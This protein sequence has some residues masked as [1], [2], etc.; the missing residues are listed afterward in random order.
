MKLA[1]AGKGG[2]GKTTLTHKLSATFGYDLLLEGA[3]ENPF[4][5]RFYH[6]QKQ[7]ALQTQLYFLLQRAE[8]LNALRQNDLFEP[9]RRCVQPLREPFVA[10]EIELLVD[11][12]ERQRHLGQSAARFVRE[13]GVVRA[14]ERQFGRERAGAPQAGQR[15]RGDL[16]VR[17]GHGIAGSLS[18][19]GVDSTDRGDARWNFR[20]RA[21]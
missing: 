14:I 21:R 9:F 8:Q 7:W 10:D 3:N 15:V 4:L 11:R 2:V 13:Q 1:F 12:I 16:D 18:S 20:R 5:E 17:V 6:D 19:I